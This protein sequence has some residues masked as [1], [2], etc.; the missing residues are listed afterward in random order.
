MEV[1]GAGRGSRGGRGHRRHR[2]D[3]YE[4]AGAGSRRAGARR[5]RRAGGSPLGG[6]L[7]TAFDAD[8]DGSVTAAEL[9]TAFDEWYDAADTPEVRIGDARSS[10][11][12]ALN[13]ALGDAGG[14]GGRRRAGGRGGRWRG[15]R[16]AGATGVRRRRDDARAERRVRRPQPAADRAPAPSD[17]EQM[18]A[19]LPTTAPAK[20]AKARKV[21][22]FSRIPSA[23]FQHSSIP[24]AAKAVEELGK[25]TGAWTSDTSWDPAVFTTENLKQYDA[26]FLSSTTGCFLDKAGDKAA[27]DARRAAFIEFVR[28][29]K[30]VAGIHATG[31]SY[32]SPCPN[33]ERRRRRPAAAA[34]AAAARTAPAA[35]SRRSSCAGRGASTTRSSRPTT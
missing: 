12:T 22:I 24:L 6:Q 34:A 25:K 9:K 28:S 35:R 3:C 30:G 1:D 5:R 33:D 11:S 14:A 18:M 26:I 20:P 16:A 15:R 13:A 29:G 27:T 23:G 19:A 17:V 7:F 32:H 8:K 10:S 2:A 31:D 21:L 4:G